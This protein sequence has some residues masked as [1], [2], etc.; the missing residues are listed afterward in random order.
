MNND[1]KIVNLQ[2]GEKFSQPITNKS[3]PIKL[4]NTLNYKDLQIQKKKEIKVVLPE[5]KEPE[6][7]PKP[8]PIKIPQYSDGNMQSSIDSGYTEIIEAQCIEPPIKEQYRIPEELREDSLMDTIDSG[9]GIEQILRRECK[10]DPH[11]KQHLCKENYLSE[12]KE[13]SEKT[14]ARTNLGIYSKS[15]VDNLL[16]ALIEIHAK[17]YVTHTQVEQMIANLDFVDSRLKAISNY[18]IP[19]FLFK[20]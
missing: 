20:L 9:F 7:K 18:E 12:F 19:E 10:C 6:I 4:G 15:E 14:L 3:T 17:D 1:L 13:E 16:E 11:Y 2:L 8:K 5:L